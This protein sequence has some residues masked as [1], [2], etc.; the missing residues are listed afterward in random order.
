ML[1]HCI[2]YYEADIYYIMFSIK[3]MG[4][5]VIVALENKLPRYRNISS[6]QVLKSCQMICSPKKLHMF[7]LFRLKGKVTL[8]TRIK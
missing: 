8:Q 7:I 6:N 4:Y 3:R 1:L 5:F 2:G